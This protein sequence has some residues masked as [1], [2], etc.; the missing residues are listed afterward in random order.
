MTPLGKGSWAF[1]VKDMLLG[2]WYPLHLDEHCFMFLKDILKKLT[3]CIHCHIVLQNRHLKVLTSYFCLTEKDFIFIILEN[4]IKLGIL[5]LVG[6][7]K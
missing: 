5:L 3:D 1:N 7:L 4:S 2:V 6:F